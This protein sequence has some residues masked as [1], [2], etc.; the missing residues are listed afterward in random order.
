MSSA[1]PL[2][3]DLSAPPL[4]TWIIVHPRENRK[5][6]S[7]EPLRGRPD[8]HFAN[9]HAKRPQFPPAGYV[10]L[11]LGGPLLTPADRDS[12]LLILDATWRLAERM[13]QT[14]SEYPVRSIPE[15]K[16][17]YPRVSKTFDDP[18]PGLATIE[19]IFAAFIATNRN[20]TTL[21]DHYHWKQQFLTL[22]HHL[23]PQNYQL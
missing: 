14:Y 5:K 1:S 2:P 4:P 8:F 3:D 9:Y 16:T 19:A 18:T 13:E 6:C 12:G 11:G 7:V 17:A 20:T 21:L 22:N 10:R 15:W 23:L